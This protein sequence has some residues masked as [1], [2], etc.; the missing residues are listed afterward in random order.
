LQL[1]ICS[2]VSFT[3]YVNGR[4]YIDIPNQPLTEGN[5]SS[6]GS[7]VGLSFN[8]VFTNANYRIR[9]AYEKQ[10]RKNVDF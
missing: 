3:N 10:E 7:F 5:Y 2:N 6:T 9:K 4:Y 8:Y 1:S